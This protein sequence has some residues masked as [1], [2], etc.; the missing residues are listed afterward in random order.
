[1]NAYTRRGAAA[2][3]ALALVS[4]PAGAGAAT[5]SSSLKGKAEKYCRALEKKD[6][7]AK[8]DKKYGKKNAMGKC[9][10][11]YEKAHKK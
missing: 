6:G 3:A 8:F 1:M 9:V 10:S 2:L 5:H 7:K 4:M 11:A